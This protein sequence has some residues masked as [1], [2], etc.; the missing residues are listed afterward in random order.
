MFV[1]L[2]EANVKQRSSVLAFSVQPNKTTRKTPNIPLRPSNTNHPRKNTLPL[3]RSDSANI[4]TKAVL[5]H[6]V[7]KIFAGDQGS[8]KLVASRPN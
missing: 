1:N 4:V 3:F 6:C 8:F 2:G 5:T 7:S